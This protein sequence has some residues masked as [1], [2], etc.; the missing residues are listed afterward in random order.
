MLS[1]PKNNYKPHAYVLFSTASEIIL[2]GV[3]QSFDALASIRQKNRPTTFISFANFDKPVSPGFV[4]SPR[5]VEMD[6]SRISLSLWLR[7]FVTREQ[8]MCK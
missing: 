2:S 1:S 6:L 3:D 5:R 4:H 7:K 8:I